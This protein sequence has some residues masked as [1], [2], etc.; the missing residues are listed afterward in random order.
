MSL[1]SYIRAMPKVELHVHLEGSIRP[2][3]LLM[4]AERNQVEL[5]ARDL[6][7]LRAWYQFRD[8]DHFLVIYKTLGKCLRTADDI[9]LIAR[10][11]LKGQ[12][13]QNIRH[14]EVT[15]TAYSQ[16]QANRIPFEDQLDAIN[17]ARDWAAVELGVTMGLIVDI[18]REIPAEEGMVTA[19]WAINGMGRGVAA[20]GLGGPEIGN[21][22]EKFKAAF[23]R[24]FA[25]GL[26]AIP[27]A[28][29]TVGPESIRG[30]L[31]TLHAVRI[32]HGVRCLEDSDLTA[33]LRERQIPLEVCPTSNICLKVFPAIEAHPLPKLM[34]EG[35]FVT[36][37][38]DDPPMFSTTLNEEYLLLDSVF[39][40]NAEMI[41][42]LALNAVR[43]SLLS[44]GEKRGLEDGFNAEFERLRKEHHINYLGDKS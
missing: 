21:P 17:R 43:V 33:E 29:E 6:D 1:A 24:A 3:T 27:H 5:P 34:A 25:A 26:P 42:Q 2:E 40:L 38:S 10:Q 4:L 12:A 31:D 37:N 41:E 36:V 23:E 28:G 8:F 22:P 13:E 18:S 20:L 39:G 9:E 16:Y 7:S 19:E 30:A 35:L 44:E 32:G 11:F 14:S 15:Y